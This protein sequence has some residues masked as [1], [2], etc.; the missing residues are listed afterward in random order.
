MILSFLKKPRGFTLVEVLTALAILSVG[1]LALAGL[2]VTTVRSNLLSKD[3]TTAVFL[4]E[5]KM[6]EFKNTTFSSLPIVTNQADPNNPLTGSGQPGGTYSRFYTIRNYS[7]SPA[8][9]QVTVSVS[10]KESGRSHS[11]TL[12]TVIAK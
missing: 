10:W 4:A 9:K 6:E 7:G 12:D 11:A 2:Q 3:L 8:M 1:L 5:Q